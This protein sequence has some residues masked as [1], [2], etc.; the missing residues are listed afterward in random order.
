MSRQH[1]CCKW[2]DTVHTRGHIVCVKHTHTYNTI[3]C[4]IHCVYNECCC[5][6]TLVVGA[7]SYSYAILG[8]C[9]ICIQPGISFQHKTHCTVYCHMRLASKCSCGM[10]AHSSSPMQS[11]YSSVT[12]V[13]SINLAT[14]AKPWH[15]QKC[16]GCMLG[17]APAVHC[18]PTW[19]HVGLASHYL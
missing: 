7:A 18:R 9:C 19:A 2:C 15:K 4:I 16:A 5:R 3:V 8:W 11:C 12:A 17:T 14:L 6:Y 13:L 1:P 10:Q